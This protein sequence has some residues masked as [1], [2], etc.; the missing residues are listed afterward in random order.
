MDIADSTIKWPSK[1]DYQ[2]ITDQFNKRVRN[3]VSEQV[4]LTMCYHS[5]QCQ[6]NN[7]FC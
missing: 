7:T 2:N 1:N 4:S 5:F 3:G 6:T